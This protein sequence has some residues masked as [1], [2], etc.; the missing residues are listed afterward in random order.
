MRHTRLER[1]PASTREVEDHVTCD[2]CHVKIGEGAIYRRDEATIKREVGQC[3]PEG[4]TGVATEVDV[5]GTCFERR[6]LPW[7]RSQDVVPRVR[8][9]TY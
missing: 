4:G 8:E 3:Y 6:V 9:F 7:L 2:L 1:V 5:C